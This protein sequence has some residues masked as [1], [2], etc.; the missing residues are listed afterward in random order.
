MKKKADGIIPS[1][2]PED[3]RVTE[4]EEEIRKM[5]KHIELKRTGV[6]STAGRD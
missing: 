5:G 6:S 2:R 1:R 3:T 4:L